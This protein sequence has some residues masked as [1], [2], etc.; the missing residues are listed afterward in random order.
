[1]AYCTG[2]DYGR[3][4]WIDCAVETPLIV[5][6][7]LRGRDREGILL[8][9]PF[10][11]LTMFPPHKFRLSQIHSFYLALSTQSTSDLGLPT[12]SVTVIETF[13]NTGSIT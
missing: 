8:S 1:M 11:R 4:V 10:F 7:I 13:N 2:L 12:H 6:T 9:G 5:N 3:K